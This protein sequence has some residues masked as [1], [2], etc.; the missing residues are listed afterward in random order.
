MSAGNHSWK[1][2]SSWHEVVIFRNAR[3]IFSVQGFKVEHW[4]GM[5]IT[6]LN[7][8]MMQTS[9]FVS[10]VKGIKR[11]QNWCYLRPQQVIPWYSEYHLPFPK[12]FL[13]IM[14]PSLESDHVSSST[15]KVYSSFI[16][17][18]SPGLTVHFF[19][20]PLTLPDFDLSSHCSNIGLSNLK[21]C[22]T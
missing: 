17:S 1:Q 6:Y 16:S 14:R 12:V 13:G 2:T 3:N 20:S 4:G 21:L 11:R 19:I 9:D 10:K 7:N 8:Y 5:K 15:P 22:L 18:G